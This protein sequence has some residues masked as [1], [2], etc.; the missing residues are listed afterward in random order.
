MENSPII[1]N[2]LNNLYDIHGNI[3]VKSDEEITE[4]LLEQI[5]NNSYN[6]GPQISLS[7]SSIIKDI[8]TALRKGIYDTIF[9][10]KKSSK[11]VIDVVKHTSFNKSIVEELEK[12][13]ETQPLTYDHILTVAALSIK[14]SLDL[15]GEGLD[16]LKI[17][18]I[19]LAHDLGKSRIPLTILQKST[20]LTHA[21]FN[22]IQ[23]HPVIEYLLL[24]SYLKNSHA[25]IAEATFSHH[26]RLDGTGYPRGISKLNNYTQALI[27][28]DIFDALVSYRPY[29]NE[30]FSIRAALD[31]LL[32]QARKG[33]ISKK[34]VICL[35]SYCRKDKPPINNII[36]SAENRDAP[37]AVNYYGV[38]AD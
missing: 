15:A 20:P 37:P 3:I 38:R 17:A 32:E 34:F 7:R 8:S 23:S 33:K 21:E 16:P 28:C 9:A 19:S 12:I 35:L 13:K 26:E 36:I 11:K 27:P 18:E 1:K 30:S 24:S 2:T 10:D 29:R 4:E 31:L 5:A 6:P 22:A 14:I 25:L